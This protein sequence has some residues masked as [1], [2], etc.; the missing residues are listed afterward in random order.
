MAPDD[1]QS[2]AEQ[3]LHVLGLADLSKAF[4]AVLSEGGTLRDLFVALCANPNRF[5]Q[6]NIF[7]EALDKYNLRNA[8]I[9]ALQDPLI[10]EQLDD[11][12]IGQRQGL[13][14]VEF[15]FA[16]P[17][18]L[19]QRTPLGTVKLQVNPTI[20]FSIDE[21]GNTSLQPGDITLR[22]L[23]VRENL[24]IRIR[25]VGAMTE[26]P[27][28]ILQV[29]AGHILSQT[30]PLDPL[31]PPAPAVAPPPPIP[32]SALAPTP[33]LP[34][35]GAALVV[36]ALLP[37][38]VRFRVYGL[39]R[40]LALKERLE[41][42]LIIRL[43][44]QRASANIFTGNLL[45][46]FDPNLSLE[47]I[48]DWIN[49]ILQGLEL[50][51]AQHLG[52]N[53]QPWHLH[54]YADVVHF[55]ESSAHNGLSNEIAAARHRDFGPN[56]LPEPQTRP[57]LEIFFDQ[58]K[59]LP[60][61]LLGVSA[62][63][64]FLTGGIAD[65]IVILGVVLVNAGIGYVTEHWAEQSIAS[66]SRGLRP[67]ALV[68]RDGSE[69]EIAGEQL[70]PGDVILLKRGM[71]VPAD[72]RLLE[73]DL[74][75]ID[76]SALTGES[77][78]ASKCVTAL[79]EYDVPLGSRHNMVYRGTVVTGGSARALV[80][81]IGLSTETGQIQRMLTETRQPETPLQR[82]LR[83]LGG[84]MA[85]LSL[86]I[87]G[88][89]FGIG[90]LRGRDLLP[91][92]KTAVSLAVAA[93][94]EG[95][96]T[97][98]TTTLA[99]GLRKLETQHVL[100]RRLA[101]VETLGALQYVCLD[102]TGT[103]TR[104]QM[105]LVAM[106]AGMTAYNLKG[107]QFYQDEE[108]IQVTTIPDLIE[109][110]ELAAL[111]SEVEITVE[112]TGVSLKGSPTETAL[113]QAALDAGIEM[114]EL[115]ERFPI[116]RTRLRSEQRSF[117]DTLHDDGAGGT[118]L[119]V[120]GSPAEMLTM[121][122]WQTKHGAIYPLREEDRIQITTENE[123]MAGRALRVLGVA[124]RHGDGSPEHD[125][126]LIWVGLA[127]IADPPRH[128][129]RELIDQFHQAGLHTIVI[130]GDQSATAYAVAKDIGLSR[131]GNLEILDSARLDELESDVLRTLAQRVDVFSRVSPTHKLKIVQ[132]LQHAGH[133]VAMTGDGVNDGPALR[134]ADIG[135][136][137]GKKGSDV[138][139]E[140][141]D[142]IV[143]DD[144]LATIIIAIEQG[145]TIYDDIKK[146]VHFILSSNT[147]EILI[148]LSATAAGLGEPLNPMQ[149]LWI[150]LVTDIFPELA[151]GVD[152]PETDVMSRPP[153]DPH[154][155]MFSEHE[156]QRIGLEGVFISASAL[157]AYSWGL[158]RYGIGP[159]AS[160]VAFTS[161]TASQLLHAISCRSQ[162]CRLNGRPFP[163]NP[164]LFLSVSGGLALQGLITLTPG[165]RR[166]LGISPLGLADW[167]V[168]A[169]A[170]IAPFLVNEM[171]KKV[172]T[173]GS[174]QE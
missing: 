57:A 68:V 96:P 104:N 34:E 45:V 70:V 88:G 16:Q 90:L 140:V 114:R 162:A 100:V 1:T 46:M 159:Q 148:T 27:R 169:V 139:Q 65:G 53:D 81:A 8:F 86:A 19:Q 58:F 117:M 69:R 161:L 2:L 120:K 63:L 55:W 144:N 95:L 49:R 126:N 73:A 35:I 89:V 124:Y 125:R 41:K 158:A 107:D 112:E 116:K 85:I 137:M 93:V 163:A 3:G 127:G 91:M 42:Q 77:I 39:Y 113:V 149:L 7:R 174:E 98:A 136:A 111:C 115:R 78:P 59:S 164:Y 150:N 47:E 62:A 166:I 9:E 72:A 21:A 33:E 167:S 135:I 132:A 138:A 160:T 26:Q 87:C 134:A 92:F 128:G 23:M 165:L 20:T 54:E 48:K 37:G 64:S 171:L 56:A 80:V 170:A 118:L 110:L 99:L 22:W 123:R 105:T 153:R 60:V 43:G 145:R 82:Q 5:I 30:I 15:R 76:E 168:S 36:I 131:Q 109:L 154:A 155:A 152:P 11:L 143:R 29:S 24:L 133:V 122:H 97:V 84:Q 25:R 6:G 44:I 50:A 38:R 18:S 32:L 129:M 17:Q 67:T 74:L 108:A 52:P 156:L 13:P 121:C 10:L 61:A 51:A 40:N 130:T 4:E 31:G 141:A 146:A 103:I 142:M 172:A 147:S 12:W 102:K 119:A 151:L 28:D 66:L 71:Y 75:T 173:T 157:A 106:F 101:A 14:I 79:T 94:P 83:V